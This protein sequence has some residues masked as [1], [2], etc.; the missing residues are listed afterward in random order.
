MDY[1]LKDLERCT[2]IKK[3]ALAKLKVWA[4]T[5]YGLNGAQMS[6]EEI[7]DDLLELVK[8]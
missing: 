3:R 1:D 5:K 8:K 4:I 7:I 2:T 6:Y